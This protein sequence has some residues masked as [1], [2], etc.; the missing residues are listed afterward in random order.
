[1][2]MAVPRARL[3]DNEINRLVICFDKYPLA[4]QFVQAVKT[5]HSI[6]NCKHFLGGGVVQNNFA[7]PYAFSNNDFTVPVRPTRPTTKIL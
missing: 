1:M 2:N 5:E 7:A 4:N 3:V 6:V